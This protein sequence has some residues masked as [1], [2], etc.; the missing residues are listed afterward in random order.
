MLESNL[1]E[2]VLTGEVQLDAELVMERQRQT[3]H[4]YLLRKPTYVAVRVY[5]WR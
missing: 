1:T 3:S 2:A 5:P 4:G